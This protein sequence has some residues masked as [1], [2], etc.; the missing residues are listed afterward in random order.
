MS[1]IATIILKG[2]EDLIG[3]DVRFNLKTKDFEGSFTNTLAAAAN[4]GVPIIVEE[5]DDGNF[6]LNSLTGNNS[7]RIHKSWAAHILQPI[8]T[9]EELLDLIDSGDLQKLTD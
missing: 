5:L 2:R 6:V 4:G 8:Q 3:E 7:L 1:K 9:T